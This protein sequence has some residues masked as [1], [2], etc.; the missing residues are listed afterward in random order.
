MIFEDPALEGASEGEVRRR[1]QKWVESHG[2]QLTSAVPRFNYP[3]LLD[4]RCVR[5]ILASA[6]PRMPTAIQSETLRQPVTDEPTEMVGYVNVVD[7]DFD[8]QSIEDEEV[9]EYYRGLVRVHM[10]CLFRF[11]YYCKR[12]MND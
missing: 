3:L 11:A 6:E 2:R 5:S 10:D 12:L 7:A 4:E 8:P 9:G 1:H